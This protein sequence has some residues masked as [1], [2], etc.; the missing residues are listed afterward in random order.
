MQVKVTGDRDPDYGS[1][2]KMFG[3]SGLGLAEDFPPSVKTGGFWTP[4]S[5]FGD[6]LIEHLVKDARL[7]FEVC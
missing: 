3:Q 2:S 5:I 4:A 1:T 6:V 7:K